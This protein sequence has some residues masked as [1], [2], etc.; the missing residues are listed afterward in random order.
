MYL[1]ETY[2]R[3]GL[4]LAVLFKKVSKLPSLSNTTTDV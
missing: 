2:L 4:F 1:L 3:V